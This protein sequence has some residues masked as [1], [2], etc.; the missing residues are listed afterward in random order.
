MPPHLRRLYAVLGLAL[1]FTTAVPL[2]RELAQPKD[3]W[4]TPAAMSVPLDQSGDRV[5]IYARGTLLSELLDAGRIQL[6]D[7]TRAT[8]LSASDVGLRF[9][10]W[11]HVRASRLPLL[12]LYAAGTGITILMFVLVI[13]GRLAYRGERAP[14][15]P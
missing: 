1:L 15:T 12:L 7:G 3:I 11:D 2:Y 14:A 9:N 6:V 5:R 10:N 8:T 4:W 13:T